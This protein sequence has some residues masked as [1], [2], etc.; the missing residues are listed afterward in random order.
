VHGDG[1]LAPQSHRYPS[2]SGWEERKSLCNPPFISSDLCSQS[3]SSGKAAL[4]AELGGY[5]EKDLF[6]ASV[7]C[8]FLKSSD[9][10]HSTLPFKLTKN[11]SGRR[12]PTNFEMLKN[13]IQ[14]L[15]SKWHPFLVSLVVLVSLG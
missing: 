5:R 13:L 2:E 3:T 11:T 4:L 12:S 14:T 15:K 1:D 9:H 6:R 7:L 8:L 10:P